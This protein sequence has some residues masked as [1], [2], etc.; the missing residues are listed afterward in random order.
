MSAHHVGGVNVGAVVLGRGQGAGR[1][2]ELT[3]IVVLI[4]RELRHTDAGVGNGNGAAVV[5]LRDLAVHEVTAGGG[6]HHSAGLGEVG[7]V[8]EVRAVNLPGQRVMEAAKLGFSRC[9]L[10]KANSQ[11]LELDASSLNGMQVTGVGS[12]YE[13]LE[14]I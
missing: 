10:P 7:L 2:P 11:K 6:R 12:I 13:L 4:Q 5:D 1:Q 3:H 9:I 14:V 8:G